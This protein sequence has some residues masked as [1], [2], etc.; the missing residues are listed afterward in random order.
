MRALLLVL[1]VGC[2]DGSFTTAPTLPPPPVCLVGSPSDPCDAA[3]HELD[4]APLVDVLAA[5]EPDEAQ[6]D[7]NTEDHHDSEP[8]A[9]LLDASVDAPFCTI[10]MP[11][12]AAGSYGYQV[13]G[14]DCVMCGAQQVCRPR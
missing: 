5:R 1:L 3:P 7:A 11:G 12:G 6:P 14:A 8:H 4:A 9:D 13:C 2:G 10:C